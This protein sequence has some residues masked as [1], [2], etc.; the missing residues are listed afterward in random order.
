MARHPPRLRP[1]SR[2]PL[3]MRPHQA[4]TRNR[5]QTNLSPEINSE[6]NW[7]PRVNP[8]AFKIVENRT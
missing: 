1:R 4:V 2:L 7:K 3:L 8:V 6:A 5:S